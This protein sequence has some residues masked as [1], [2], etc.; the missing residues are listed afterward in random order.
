MQTD[1]TVD[2]PGSELPSS[3][4]VRLVVWLRPGTLLS[5][6]LDV[7]LDD[8][9]AMSEEWAGQR[10]QES[11]RVGARVECLH[12]AEGGTLAAHDASC[13]VDLTVQDDGTA[14]QGDNS[15]TSEWFAF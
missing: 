11:P 12:V 15:Q 13:G 5:A 10:L 4:I 6:A 7:L 9:A 14:K 2:R 3:R 1:Q 8:H